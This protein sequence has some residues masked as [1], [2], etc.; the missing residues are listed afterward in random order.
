MGIKDITFQNL[1]KGI[2]KGASSLGTNLKAKWDAS[3]ERAKEQA[4]KE[5][6]YRDEAK[7]FYQAELDKQRKKEVQKIALQ[8][9]KLDAKL[10]AQKMF[11]PKQN[12]IGNLFP[13]PSNKVNQNL[14]SSLSA[15]MGTPRKE[16]LKKSL[17]SK[18]KKGAPSQDF[19]DLIW[20]S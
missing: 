6:A 13:T 4:I 12:M 5:R 18:I 7:V 17:K 20:K 1:G 16:A 14:N 11:A 2:S 3:R 19:N 9:A 8:K 15:F 10:H